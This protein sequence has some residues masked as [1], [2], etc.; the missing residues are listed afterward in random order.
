MV[1]C[2]W[3]EFVDKAGP[4]KH[5][6]QGGGDV[7]VWVLQREESGTVGRGVYLQYSSSWSTSP[8]FADSQPLSIM[9]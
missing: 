6:A 5:T 9:A 4:V 7:L 3:Q 8:L 1:E 2:V